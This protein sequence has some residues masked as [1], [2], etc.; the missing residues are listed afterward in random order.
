MT[1]IH[2]KLRAAAIQNVQLV[3]TLSETCYSSG[4]WQ[5]NNNYILSLKKDIT[6]HEKKLHEVNIIADDSFAL[7][8]YSV[9]HM[10]RLADKL[11][12]KNH[13]TNIMNQPTYEQLRWLDAVAM[14]L[15]TRNALDNLHH[16][17][18]EA[19]KQGAEL[20]DIVKIHSSTSLELDALYVNIFR[21]PI[22]SMPAEN[23]E[24]REVLA[25]EQD[26]NMFRLMLSNELQVSRILESANNF[27]Q[28]AL[29]DIRDANSNTLVDA[30]G[31]GG[32]WVEFAEKSELARCQQNVSQTCIL[33]SRAKRLQGL[34]EPV[35]DML[36][37]RLNYMPDFSLGGDFGAKMKDHI[38]FCMTQVRKAKSRLE[39]QIRLQEERI[40]VSYEDVHQAGCEL[41]MRREELQAVRKEVFERLAEEPDLDLQVFERVF[42]SRPVATC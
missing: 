16:D 23:S 19:V 5:Q 6:K 25:A 21:G 34:V 2:S 40:K 20:M 3:Q 7:E 8:Y 35:G 38:T 12:G 29:N 17:L 30:W 18:G 27:L 36:V 24:Q 22:P 13:N 28:L 9:A 15:A 42:N 41:E 39:G 26:Y 4:A 10:K 1:N 37:G 31:L 32:T 14:Q 11:D 33:M